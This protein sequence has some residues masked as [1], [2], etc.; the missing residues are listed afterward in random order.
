MTAAEM[1]LLRERIAQ[2]SADISDP[3]KC[4]DEAD[5][6]EIEEHISSVLL[7]DLSVDS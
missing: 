4:W 6:G 5:A 3:D 2:V 7:D 1:K